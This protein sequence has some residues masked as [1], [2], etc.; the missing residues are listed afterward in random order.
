M[1]TAWL[2]SFQD[3]EVWEFLGDKV[4]FSI[5]ATGLDLEF[6]ALLFSSLG[7]AVTMDGPRFVQI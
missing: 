1:E 7:P 2:V 4:A 3:T 6:L 5:M